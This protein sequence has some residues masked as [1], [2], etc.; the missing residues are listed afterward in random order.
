MDK[1]SLY[2][3]DYEYQTESYDFRPY[4][5]MDSEN[6]RSDMKG[7]KYNSSIMDEA[8]VDYQKEH[9]SHQQLHL[10][11][12]SNSIHKRADSFRRGEA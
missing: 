7:F 4:M 10:D 5:S 3:S 2:D 8:S 12:K 1:S 11:Q 9:I 6:Q